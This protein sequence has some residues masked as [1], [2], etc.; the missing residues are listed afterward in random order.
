MVHAIDVARFF[1]NIANT[2][3]T[4]DLM[5]NMRV[6]KLLYFAQGECLR[7]LGRPLFDEDMEAWQYGPVVPHV[8][9]T[10]K[11]F[12]RGPINDDAEYQDT[13]S[14]QEKNILFDVLR[15]YGQ[16]STSRLVALSHQENAPW[17]A[18]HK[19][20]V[21]HAKMSNEA[22]KTFFESMDSISKFTIPYKETDFVGY[23]DKDGYLVLPKEWDDEE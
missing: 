14:E 6:N 4:D 7:Q 21:K 17:T 19:D 18:A 20:G 15:Y 10:Y 23:R 22:I 1:I 8:Y 3:P 11:R 13:L 9:Q 2:I 5:T 12:G 16:F